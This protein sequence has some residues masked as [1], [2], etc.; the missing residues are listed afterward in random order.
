MSTNAYGVGL[1]VALSAVCLASGC[2]RQSPTPEPIRPVKT[3]V[4]GKGAEFY[5][6][7]F[8]GRVEAAQSVELAFQVPGLVTALP[9]KE[10]QRVARGQVL[11]QLRQTEYQARSEAAR[12]QLEQGQALLDALR[13]GAR[14]QEQIRLEA[15]LRAAEA[16]LANARTEFE[17]YARLLPTT[18]V[19]RSDYDI[20][21]T[22]YKVAG[23][24]RVS[25]QQ[26][27]EKA[28]TARQEEITAQEAQV[29]T[30]QAR[31]QEA[32]VQF[33]DTTL[34][35]P[36]NGVVA[37]RLI[38]Q[39]QAI[40]AN[41]PVVKF[42]NTEEVDIVVD[43]PEAVMAAGLQGGNVGV[44]TAGFSYIPGKQFPVRISEIAQVADPATQTFPAHFRMKQ[45]AG[46][47]LLPGMTATVDIAF[48]RP[49][50]LASQIF[51]PVSA[52]TR[53]AN[54]RQV[55]WVLGSDGT[56]RSRDV[57]M[58]AVQDGE[59]EVLGGLRPGERIA[60][61]GAEQLRDGMKVRDLGNALGDM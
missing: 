58:R 18:A 34:R 20:S 1:G 17:R 27:L 14:S 4:V 24:E 60:V 38:D 37:Q 44:M 15:A 7:T 11:S 3:M 56:V 48:R 28:R 59:V 49:S 54:G 23:E 25:A 40:T 52:V 46:M 26:L 41:R 13:S 21:E 55:V 30:L 51:V 9:V 12:G 10:G 42:Q 53:Q 2:R 39:G 57:R 50:A 33:A 45:P 8:P 6:R 31:V 36:Y 19:S 47:T 29:H 16:K 43:V 22:N 61:A 35:A 5:V 32:G